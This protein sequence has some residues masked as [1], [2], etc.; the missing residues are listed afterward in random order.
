M[1]KFAK[2]IAFLVL[3]SPSLASAQTYTRYRL[4]AGTRLTVSGSTYQG[5]NLGEYQQLLQMDEDL[6]HLTDTA[7]AAAAQIA[8]LTTASTE[9]QRAIAACAE[10]ATMLQAERVRLTG[11]WEE[12][13]RKRQEAEQHSS[14]EWLPWS[15]AGG[16]LVST[17]VLGLVVGLVR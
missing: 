10:R 7:A 13:S 9:F 16:F 15:L 8:N 11:M 3:F 12:E 14:W 2:I 1:L 6:R 4:P 5:F 17:V